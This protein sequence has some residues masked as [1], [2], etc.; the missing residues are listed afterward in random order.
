MESTPEQLRFQE[1]LRTDGFTLSLFKASPPANLFPN[2]TQPLPVFFEQN[3]VSPHRI[4]KHFTDNVHSNI[5][6]LYY[7][8]LRVTYEVETEIGFNT[9]FMY[10]LIHIVFHEEFELLFTPETESQ[11]DLYN[12][13]QFK[14]LFAEFIV[15]LQNEEQ[16]NVEALLNSY[17]VMDSVFIH[18]CRSILASQGHEYSYQAKIP[19]A[20][21]FSE[22]GHLLG[23]T[24]E[25]YNSNCWKFSDSDMF[26]FE[27][28]ENSIYLAYIQETSPVSEDPSSGGNY[29]YESYNTGGTRI[30]GLGLYGSNAG[31][32]G[33][34]EFN[35]PTVPI[36]SNIG[37]YQSL[38]QM[39]DRYVS[40]EPRHDTY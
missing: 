31:S 7:Q 24:I 1:A 37:G 4:L 39:A 10:N 15:L 14:K 21:V 16:P 5:K 3:L 6:I 26:C 22:I 38:D 11:R 34:G 29:S 8:L 18:I 12:D 17:P 13:F 2:N 28:N 30:D 33:S 32:T 19:T 9:N 40:V 35:R 20:V 27:Q 23:L 25:S 36:T